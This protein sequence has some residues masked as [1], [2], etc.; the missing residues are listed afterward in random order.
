MALMTQNDFINPLFSL[1]PILVAVI[2]WLTGWGYLFLFAL[3]TNSLDTFLRH[4]GFMIGDFLM[5]PLAGFLITFFYQQFTNPISLITSKNWTYIALVIGLS[6]AVLSA[7]RTLFVWKTA[8][9]DILIIPHFFFYWFI[10]YI[11]INFFIKG[12]LQN[13][14][15]STPL[16]W[17]IY[18]GVILVVLV[19]LIL[20][21]IFDPKIF[22]VT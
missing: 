7:Y 18:I 13:L 21:M 3:R 5:L 2:I 22:P 9:V 12:L 14:S 16:S 17:L 4:P 6:L 10:S 8:P 19:H 11:L 1:N 20:P 15:S